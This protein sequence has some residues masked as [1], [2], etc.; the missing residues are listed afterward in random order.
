MWPTRLQ[1]T[2]AHLPRQGQDTWIEAVVAL[3]KTSS[4]E[5]PRPG[6]QHPRGSAAGGWVQG[7]RVMTVRGSQNLWFGG[8]GQP[9]LRE[10]WVP[11]LSL[12]PG[13]GAKAPPAVG[14][15]SY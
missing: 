1:A 14:H 6:V 5:W 13:G 15:A 9:Q 7:L 10:P 12:P 8:Q 4:R 2:V 11:L 3:R